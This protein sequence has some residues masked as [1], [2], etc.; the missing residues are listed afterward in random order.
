MENN[1][2][3]AHANFKETDTNLKYKKVALRNKKRK[4]ELPSEI[5]TLLDLHKYFVGK[6]KEGG[7]EK[8]I[9]VQKL[10]DTENSIT[11]GLY[12]YID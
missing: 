12:K 2:N 10:R 11:W 9:Y 3:F 7:S 4:I 1:E 6:V 8:D 5:I